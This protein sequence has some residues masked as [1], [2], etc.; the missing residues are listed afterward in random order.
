MAASHLVVAVQS[1]FRFARYWT[2]ILAEEPRQNVQD[3][4]RYQSPGLTEKSA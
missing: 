4:A 1:P 2:S 3:V